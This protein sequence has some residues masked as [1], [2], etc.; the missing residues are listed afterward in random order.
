MIDLKVSV[1][2]EKEIARQLE[3]AGSEIRAAVREELAAVGD[4]IVSR[5]QAMAPKR[6]GVM[7]SKVLWYFGLERTARQM[8]KLGGGRYT[9][10]DRGPII[11]TVRPTGSVAHLME[12]GVNATRQAHQRKARVVG[13]V[14]GRKGKRTVDRIGTVFVKAHPF[15]I[16]KRP[17][18]MPAVESVGGASGVNA[19]LQEAIDGVASRV[20]SG[21]A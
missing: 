16:G 14:W 13:T 12:R 17:F 21:A 20:R 18:F 10:P 2:G 5:A 1:L 4:E 9:D 15:K 6:T 3:E 8:R 11:F 19:R 7:A